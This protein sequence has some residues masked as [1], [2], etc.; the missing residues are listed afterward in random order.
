MIYTTTTKIALLIYLTL[1]FFSRSPDDLFA[2]WIPLHRIS[3][4]NVLFFH[5]IFNGKNFYMH[6]HTHSKRKGSRSFMKIAMHDRCWIF[7]VCESKYNRAKV[8]IFGQTTEGKYGYGTEGEWERVASEWTVGEGGMG[9]NSEQLVYFPQCIQHKT[10][11]QRKQH[12]VIMAFA[13]ALP[14]KLHI[15]L[16]DMSWER[17]RKCGTVIFL[18]IRYVHFLFH[19]PAGYL[20]WGLHGVLCMAFMANIFVEILRCTWEIR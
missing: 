6:T 17:R 20:L 2:Q 9:D 15:S 11:V 8:G 10:E 14:D 16:S 4:V 7:A 13:Q 3:S 12:N 18:I 1:S 5:F 19:P